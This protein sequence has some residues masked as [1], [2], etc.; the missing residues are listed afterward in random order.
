[1][2]RGRFALRHAAP[3]GYPAAAVTAPSRLRA[4]RSLAPVLVVLAVAGAVGLAAAWEPI[5]LASARGLVHL[6]D[7]HDLKVYWQSSRWVVGEGVLYRDVESEYPLAAN[8]LF[9]AARAAARLGPPFPEPF[10]RFA[11]WWMSGAWAAYLAT[12][13]VVWTRVPGRPI[14]LW[15]TP[16]ALHFSLLRYDVYP[17]LATLLAALAAR[18]DR[19]RRA[20]LWLGVAIAL[21]GYG[22]FLLPAW[23]VFV[24]ARAGIREAAR[25]AA[26]ALLPLVAGSLLA[27]SFSGMQ[28]MLSP[29]RAQVGFSFNGES[30]WD[31]LRIAF[32][33][34]AFGLVDALSRWRTAIVLAVALL[35]AALRPRS[36]DALML[37]CIVALLGYMS[38]TF[39]YSPQWVLWL[40]PF[41]ML[42]ASRLVRALTL[43][44][45]WA[46]YL[47]FPVLYFRHRA[48][49]GPAFGWSVVGIASLR[50]ALLATA[51][52]LLARARA[53][54][55]A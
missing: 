21:K 50:F 2:R 22:V 27:L 4:T 52:A 45:S 36:F 33:P 7:R 18:E 35:A 55:P 14:W 31:A 42:G 25:F 38:F 19:H 48:R 44:L 39:V 26:L 32:G 5:R 54:R 34:A 3:G 23:T 6:H 11:W 15:L 40:V 53:G 46:T 12:L 24:G 9:G 49:G 43:L 20:A 29:F 13:Y 51:G 28:G 41:T 10:D 8:L 17:I 16:T 1:M 47:Y 37:A 30:T